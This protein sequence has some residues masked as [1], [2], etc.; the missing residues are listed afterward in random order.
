MS[1]HVDLTREELRE[2][3]EFYGRLLASNDRGHLSKH[4]QYRRIIRASKTAIN[5]I[6]RSDSLREEYDILLYEYEQLTNGAEALRERADA[7]NTVVLLAE[8]TFDEFDPACKI[9]GCDKCTVEGEPCRSYR[10]AIHAARDAGYIEGEKKCHAKD[11]FDDIK[12]PTDGW[13]GV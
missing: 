11:L 3:I 4:A 13:V 12:K 10:K 5:A 2:D 1:E 8:K 6:E 7:L 9:T